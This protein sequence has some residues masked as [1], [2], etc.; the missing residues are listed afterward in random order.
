MV[1]VFKN[2]FKRS[3]VERETPEER[4]ERE[5]R[6][7]E[8]RAE[9]EEQEKAQREW[10][11]QQVEMSMSKNMKF[12]RMWLGLDDEDVD[13]GD[14]D[15]RGAGDCAGEE[16]AAG[17]G[18]SNVEI[19]GPRASAELG[20]A[21]AG[22]ER[23]SVEKRGRV[24]VEMRRSVEDVRTGGMR[25]SVEYRRQREERA[26]REE[27]ERARQ[28]EEE[29]ERERVRK[30]QEAVLERE[31]EEERRREVIRMEAELERERERE[32]E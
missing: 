9:R 10:D 27:E 24:S 8:E 1:G 21:G 11:H 31:R 14:R 12:H 23:Q 2:P 26:R 4:E 30:E 5:E 29:R 6:E 16:D 17:V 32:R 18:R 28:E 15:S 25:M 7:R 20:G 19:R 13:G 3:S 22:R